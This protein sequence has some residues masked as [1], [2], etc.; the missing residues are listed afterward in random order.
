M[1][2]VFDKIMKWGLSNL[3]ITATEFIDFQKLNVTRQME[4]FLGLVYL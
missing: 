4:E 2:C 1:D 3:R